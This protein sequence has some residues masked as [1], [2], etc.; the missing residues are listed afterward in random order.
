MENICL[1]RETYMLNVSLKLSILVYSS[2][3][4]PVSKKLLLVRRY[5][6]FIL[7][8]FSNKIEKPY[9]IFPAS[10]LST[11]LQQRRFQQDL[12]P[13]FSKLDLS[14]NKKMHSSNR[15]FTLAF[16]KINIKVFLNRT[17]ILLLPKKKQILKE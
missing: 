5:L 12:L 10:H 16:N 17:N 14:D 4:Y 1:N 6:H 9:T 7:F 11:R 3:L 8:L 2:C 15:S 13:R